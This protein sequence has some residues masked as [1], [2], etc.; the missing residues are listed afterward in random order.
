MA[1]R[2]IKIAQVIT[3]MDRGGAPDI[4]KSLFHYLTKKGYDVTLISGSTTRPSLDTKGF[5]RDYREKMIM[6]PELQRELRPISDIRAFIKLFVLFKKKKFDIIHTHTAKAGFLGR[7]AAR[8][9]GA[10]AVVHTPHGHNFYGY[11]GRLKSRLIIMLERMAALF[12]DRIIAL[13]DIEKK[14]MFWYNICPVSKISVVRSGI[15]LVRY[16]KNGLDKERKKSELKI[17]ADD[18][19][20]GMMA[21]LERVKGAAYFIEA[22]KYISDEFSKAKFLIVGDGPLKENLTLLAR[23]LGIYDKITFTGWREDIPDILSITDI[24]VLPSLNEAVGRILL[25]AGASGK[26][27]VAT[28]VGGVPEIIRNGETGFLVPPGD[29]K[30]IAE[31]VVSLLKDEKKRLQMGL[32]AKNRV[33]SDFNENRMTGEIHDLYEN[34]VKV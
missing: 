8:L 34:L 27:I 7:I 23:R 16:N 29:S 13:T 25:E 18:F 26:P 33:S 2:K 30:K 3:R 20:V 10:C 21:R 1:Q 4:V 5:L 31:A 32:T 9:A 24:V 11:F 22:V 14:D 6:M 15:D 17:N 12:A 28:A 19:L